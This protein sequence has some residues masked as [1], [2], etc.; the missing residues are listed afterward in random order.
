MLPNFLVEETIVRESG[1]S[2]V[3]DLTN[4]YSRNLLVTFGITHAVE[5]ESID[6]DIYG[7]EDGRTWP[8][9]PLASFTPKSYCGT[10]DLRL[11]ACGAGYLKAVWSVQRWSRAEVQP[12]FRIYVC[13]KEA[14]VRTMT[15][16][17]A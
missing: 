7:S 6:V 12:F 5:R 11:P 17:A 3:F 13:V 10:Y 16:G 2:A 4:H 8:L 15:A 14:R 9:R 1:Q